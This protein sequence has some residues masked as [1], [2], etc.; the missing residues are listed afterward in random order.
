MGDALGDGELQGK[1]A[2]LDDDAG[3]RWA[4]SRLLA[5]HFIQCECYASAH[6]FLQSLEVATPACLITDLGMEGMTG[7]ELL[8]YLASTGLRIP[9][10][11]LTA[12]DEPGLRHRCELA[13]A[14]QF[15]TK[16]VS[17]ETL[18]AAVTSVIVEGHRRTNSATS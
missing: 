17:G 13:G 1:I 3:V 5:A 16:P 18:L 9:T 11:V 8:H 7:L 15:L 14:A 4:V 12:D 6:E 2:I 10:I